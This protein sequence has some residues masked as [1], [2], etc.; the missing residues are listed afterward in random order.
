MTNIFFKFF[1][2]KLIHHRGPWSQ[3]KVNVED[4]ISFVLGIFSNVPGKK[5]TR[6]TEKIAGSKC[7][8]R[9]IMLG[10]FS[11]TPLLNSKIQVQIP[12]GA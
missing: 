3:G 5:I 2:F 9:H 10:K 12:S 4:S 7:K 11:S 8:E 6:K 1:L